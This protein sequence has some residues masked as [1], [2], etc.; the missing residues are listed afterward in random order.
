M[1]LSK[2]IP[3]LR[4]EPECESEEKKAQKLIEMKQAELR[5]RLDLLVLEKD[6]LRRQ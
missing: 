2:L 1:N 6:I 5:K 3:F 4:G